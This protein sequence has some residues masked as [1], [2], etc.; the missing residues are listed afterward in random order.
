[1]AATRTGGSG[2]RRPAQARKA[3]GAGN[4]SAARDPSPTRRR[5]AERRG[6]RPRQRPTPAAGPSRAAAGK[7]PGPLRSFGFGR[8]GPL[9]SLRFSSPG[10]HAPFRESASRP[11]HARHAGR[12]ARLGLTRPR[13]RPARRPV[14]GDRPPARLSRRRELRPERNAP[15][16][17]APS[18]P[19][20]AEKSTGCA[21]GD[22]D[23]TRRVRPGHRGPSAGAA[24]S[25]AGGGAAEERRAVRARG[26]LFSPNRAAAGFSFPRLLSL[27]LS[28]VFLSL[29]SSSSRTA[30]QSAARGRHPRGN[31]TRA[32]ASTSKPR[33]VFEGH[34]RARGATRPSH[35]PGRSSRPPG[36]GSGDNL[37]CDGKRIGKETALPEHRTPP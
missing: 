24:R 19:G 18:P 36:S 1:M 20:H 37:A 28:G 14:A 27:S 25:A 13:G 3:P 32:G 11:R 31:T 5:A 21:R 23:P 4:G 9:F 22:S 7:E 29:G 26:G 12:G 34:L 35:S 10:G 2:G 16:G 17:R 8:R 30:A 15:P 6:T 33:V